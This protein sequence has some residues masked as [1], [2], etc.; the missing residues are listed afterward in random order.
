MAQAVAERRVAEGDWI[1]PRPRLVGIMVA[2][3]PRHTRGSPDVQAQGERCQTQSIGSVPHFSQRIRSGPQFIQI[4]ELPFVVRF[5][6][7][8][9]VVAAG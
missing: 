5:A 1:K 7:H 3:D 8:D 6:A 2:G 4:R 9:G